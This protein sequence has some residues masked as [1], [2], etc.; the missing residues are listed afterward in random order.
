MC[1]MFLLFL[2]GMTSAQKAE[3]CWVDLCTAILNSATSSFVHG[4]VHVSIGLHWHDA[5]PHSCWHVGNMQ[6]LL[7]IAEAPYSMRTM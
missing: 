6:A 7:Q 2:A 1:F 5:R 4:A 3:A